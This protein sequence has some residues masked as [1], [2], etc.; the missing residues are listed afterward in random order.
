MN[1]VT[2]PDPRDYMALPKDCAD[3][4]TALDETMAGKTVLHLHDMGFGTPVAP[5]VQAAVDR[6]AALFADMGAEVIHHDRLYE[7]HMFNE[8]AAGMMPIYTD[9]MGQVSGGQIDKLLE[10]TQSAHRWAS[11]LSV[12]EIRK[13]QRAWAE[14]LSG[15]MALFER[16]DFILCPTLNETAFDADLIFPSGAPTNHYGYAYDFASFI[17]P[18]NMGALPACSVPAGLDEAGLPIGIQ[19]IGKRY[20]DYGVLAASAAYEAARGD[21]LAFPKTL[22]S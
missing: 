2:Q 19:I 11:G 7:R 22:G 18:V 12:D 5:A 13:G 10:P 9:R 4:R 16:A 20:D 8:L 3:Y 6:A 21:V 14:A 15:F 17:Y 1:A